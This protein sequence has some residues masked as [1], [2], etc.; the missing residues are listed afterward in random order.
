MTGVTNFISLAQME[1]MLAMGM[2]EG[3]EQAIG[4]IDDVLSSTRV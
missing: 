1:T 3:M 4:Q 2:K